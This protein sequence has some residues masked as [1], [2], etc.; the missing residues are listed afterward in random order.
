MTKLRSP[1][2][3]RLRL[4]AII[5]VPI[6][7]LLIIA[8]A[9]TYRLVLSFDN[10]EHDRALAADARA[11]ASLLAQDGHLS[12]QAS[13]LLSYDAEGHNYF[14]LQSNLRG[15]L[16]HTDQYVPPFTHLDV[17]VAPKFFDARIGSETVRAVTLSVQS[18][19]DV[20]EIFTVT[21]A[22]SLD[23]RARL[24]DEM[25]LITLILYGLL[26]TGL[27]GLTGVGVWLGLRSLQPLIDRLVL[28][29]QSLEAVT[30][31]HVPR[32]I[33]PLTQTIDSSFLRLRTAIEV[34]EQ[35]VADAAHQLRTPLAGLRLHSEQA[36]ATDDPKLVRE[37]LHHI[38]QLTLRA[39]RTANQ[40]LALLQAQSSLDTEEFHTQIDLAALVRE[41]VIEWVPTGLRDRIDFG[42]QG[43]DGPLWL[44]GNAA[45]LHEL[46]CNLLHNC[47]TYGGRGTRVTV[48]LQ[49]NQDGSIE[50]CVSDDG[51]GVPADCLPRLGERFYRVPGSA[52][53]GTGLGLAIAAR[54]AAR[55]S[56]TLRFGSSA[57]GGLSVILTFNSLT[58]TSKLAPGFLRQP[59]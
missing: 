36:L 45:A 47:Q 55:H 4:Q 57:E 37:S 51:K 3:L 14:V 48:S 54:I 33:L 15:D 11:I 42:Y 17:G 31:D 21:L 35:F 23:S 22:E 59:S 7:L 6:V 32:E 28:R 38:H 53:G 34:Q 39:S 58:S 9:V 50:L 27:V 41:T 24:A 49:S 16:G 20:H 25:L 43:T 18:L 8:S 44:T 40:L 30:D 46:L 2:S 13:Y 26:V 12:D 10:R 56:A 1:P 29:S 19:T 5:V 52:S